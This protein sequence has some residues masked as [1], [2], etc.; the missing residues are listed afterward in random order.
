[1]PLAAELTR[2]PPAPVPWR[3]CA[4]VLRHVAERTGELTVEAQ[5]WHRARLL[6]AVA[7]GVEPDELELERVLEPERA[8]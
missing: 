3:V 4:V 8:A 5:S 2:P 7:L 1:M 6:M